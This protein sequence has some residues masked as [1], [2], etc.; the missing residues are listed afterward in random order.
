MAET[1]NQSQIVIFTHQH[2][3]NG[4]IFLRDQRHLDFLNG[5]L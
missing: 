2:S 1:T 5:P 3:I 4:G